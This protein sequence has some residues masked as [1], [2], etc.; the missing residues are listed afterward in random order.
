MTNQTPGNPLK[1]FITSARIF[2]L[3]TAITVTGM[4]IVPL[5]T[6]GSMA[7]GMDRPDSWTTN[8]R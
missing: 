1:A 3:L 8:N 6:S 7:Y 5:T 2:I 4:A